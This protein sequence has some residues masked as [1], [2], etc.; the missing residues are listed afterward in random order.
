MVY[1]FLSFGAG[2]QT[3]ALLLTGEYDEVIFAD[4]GGELP[5]TYDYIRQN[6]IPYCHDRGVRFTTVW[7]MR[8][9]LGK[10]WVPDNLYDYCMRK[11]RTPMMKWR[12]TT[13]DWKI[14]PIR[15]YVAK[16]VLKA[17]Q[18]DAK[19]CI[20]VMGI[21]YDEADRVSKEHPPEYTKVYPLVDA[22]IRREDCKRVILKHGWQVPM[23]SGCFFCCY[24]NFERLQWLQR[25]HPELYWKFELMER[26]FQARRNKPR[27]Y[28]GAYGTLNELKKKFS[29]PLDAFTPEPE[30]QCQIAGY[31]MV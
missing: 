22:K 13:R 19:D 15:R 18:L 2:V 5:E 23:K 16:Y 6:V 7:K 26:N 9:F 29:L 12:W 4:T 3:T 28:I 8:Q 25:V 10:L 17:K 30:P 1:R 11:A 14:L 31:C 24:A 21:S 20:C 27:Y